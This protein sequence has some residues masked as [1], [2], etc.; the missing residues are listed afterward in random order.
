MQKVEDVV[1]FYK[2]DFIR[3]SEYSKNIGKWTRNY[4]L[5]KFYLNHRTHNSISI[6][7]KNHE[8]IR[9]TNKQIS[10]KY[11]DN[12][13][14]LSDLYT[15]T[16]SPYEIL[17]IVHVYR[18]DELP[19]LQDSSTYNYQRPLNPD[20][21][22]EIRKNLL[23]D[24]DFIFPSN[25]LVILS[26]ECKYMKD[27]DGNSCLY[28]PKKYGSISVIDGQHRLFSYAD[29][30]VKLMMQDDCK[31]MV[32][33]VYFRTD[34]QEIITKFSARVFIEINFLNTLWQGFGKN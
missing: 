15:F 10:K 5:N 20:K 6:Y 14:R 33:A 12:D 31:I 4:F 30:N 18:Q 13:A 22:K 1:I 32:T 8:L 11:E 24:C 21:L 34:E 9:S 2:S 23:T 29:E 28:I 26:K 25:I 3:L 16:I 17:D 19:S 27:G 7:E